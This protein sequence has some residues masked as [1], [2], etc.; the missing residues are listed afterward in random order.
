M[1]KTSVKENPS[2]LLLPSLNHDNEKIQCCFL[3]VLLSMG[4]AP[5][6][7]KVRPYVCKNTSYDY[8]GK[9]VCK[10][11]FSLQRC[12]YKNKYFLVQDPIEAEVCTCR[13]EVLFRNSPWDWTAR[14]W[15]L[16]NLKD[17]YHSKKRH[18]KITDA[19][20]LAVI[21]CGIL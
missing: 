10:N 8:N 13:K 6:D 9:K 20:F 2:E 7:L 18:R 21:R 12:I 11:H 16:V 1:V 4:C 17:T 19:F 5:P 15:K 3:P 14:E